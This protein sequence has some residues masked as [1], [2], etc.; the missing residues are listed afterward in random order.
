MMGKHANEILVMR[1]FFKIT[2]A[3]GSTSR[4]L[5]PK[6]ALCAFALHSLAIALLTMVF[7]GPASAT[8]IINAPM[9]DTNSTGWTLGGTPS[10]A[11]LTGN[12]AIDP[13]GNGWLRL[14]NATGNQTGFAY[15]NTAFDLSAGLLIEFDYATWGGTGA[16][17]YSVYL[18]DAGVSPFNIGAF[19]GSLGYAQKG[20]SAS[21]GACTS[22][23]NVPGISGGYVGIGVDEFGNFADCGEGRYLSLNNNSN[24]VPNTISIRGPV[25]GFGGGAVGSTQSTLSYP[26][27][28]TS[29]T[30]PSSL[31]YNG[32][33]RPAQTSVNYRHVRIQISPAPNPVANV[34]V[35]FGYS[36]PLVF[37]QMISNATLPT[38]STSQ[39]LMIGYAASTGGSTNYHEIRNLL[40]SNQ[41]TTS[42]IDLAITKTFT[43]V[44]TGST[45]TAS[46]G[47]QVRY[48]V[49]A[50]NTGPNNVT[51]T[52]VG[53]VDTVPAAITGVNW[54]CAGSGGAT[55]GAAS[56][57]G[58]NINTTANLPLYGYVTYTITGTLGTGA[59]SLLTN[60]AS[61][62][63]P[64]SV[65]DYN[66]TDDSATVSI[67]VTSVVTA[68]KSVVD[69]NNT[70][71]NATIG[72]VLQ[73]TITLTET[74][75]VPA[76]VSVTDDMPLNVTNFNVVSAPTGSDTSTPTGGANN[77]GYLNI[78][79]INIP[80][81]GTVSIV[82]A[83]SIAGSAV[84]GTVIGNTATVTN[85]GGSGATPSAP[86][87]IVVAGSGKKQLYLAGANQLSRTPT[88]SNPAAVSVNA[89]SSASWT[90]TPSLAGN[91]TLNPSIA[92]NVTGTLYMRGNS[93]T[94]RTI[95]VQLTCPTN[96]VA[97]PATPWAS[98]NFTLSTTT[99]TA[100]V[101]SLS[102]GGVSKTCP[103]GGQWILTVV[104]TSGGGR[105]ISIYPQSVSP[106]PAGIS[107]ILL[108]S[109]N[110]INVDSV[111]AYDGAYPAGA[112]LSSFTTGTIYVR[113][114]VSD[115][116]GYYDI[117][118]NNNATTQPTI[119][120]KDPSGNLVK[121]TAMPRAAA[122][123]NNP[124]SATRTFEYQFLPSPVQ[125]GNWTA[126]VTAPEGT[127]GTVSDTRIGTFLVVLPPPT[128]AKSFTPQSV[129]TNDASVLK[130]TLTNPNGAAITG[131]A[132]TDTYPSGL[133]STATPSTA[134]TCG[135]TVTGAANGNSL[136]LSNGTIPANGSCTV[137]I[138]AT[139]ATAGIYSN[140]TGTITSTNAVSAAPTSATLTV[141]NHPTV[142][143][144]FTP[145][146][147]VTNGTSTLT[148]NVTNSNSAI[149][150]GATFTDTYPANLKN[151]ASASA[152]TT[153][154]GCT[155]TL[156]GANNGTSLTLT[157]ANIP[158]N[159]T[160][161]FTVNVTS[162]TTGTYTNS[163]GTI[164]TT[165]AGSGT[166]ASASL[167]VYDPA[168]LTVLKS[169]NVA[170]ANPGQVITYTIQTANTGA[171]AGT[172]VVLKN[173]LSPYTAFGLN[174]YGANLPFSFTD[175]SPAS[176]LSLGTPVYSNDNGS[177]WTYTPVSGG[178][179][180]PAGYD[181]NITNWKI[182]MTGTI[183]AGGSFVLNYKTIVK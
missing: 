36:S 2:K 144:S 103:S 169:A 35:S 165:N 16:D 30:A 179:G 121:N 21:G 177:T 171:G 111:T 105:T 4:S 149:I 115:P 114:V 18:F 97:I 140:S 104:N 141:L 130:I 132:F 28:A 81:N 75:G 64:G 19:G 25:V 43:D 52:G 77:A 11:I 6:A 183:R 142:A 10:S 83:V 15:N 117:D 122:D 127:E 12:G 168:L 94:T 9:T 45:T 14:T 73:Y 124:T 67:P 70:L 69:L 128:V 24:V 134:T 98:G 158:A 13:V 180:A 50:S 34:W 79:N 60:T 41:N 133:V 176:G 92:T 129:G 59:P 22:T 23:A 123:P 84:N 135:G 106:S 102:L 100:V 109:A 26:W 51:A 150:T 116:F 93:T 86:N 8:I 139:S 31:W 170:N 152:T 164:T 65:T 53:I 131:A 88:S 74:A 162:A 39:Q 138:N 49:V 172:N 3:Y 119:V 90:L 113:A 89:G 161:T 163:T 101:F 7:A 87:V 27:V 175:S 37:T 5:H 44:T 72:D 91:D 143:T 181:G 62:V 61:L 154:T 166:A 159:A 147:V 40:V 82:F 96:G 54:T 156:T 71:A 99:N 20:T 126:T 167:S 155:G 68:T 78:T 63:I 148:I 1:Y 120:I 125:A 112:A 160:C 57:S 173:D 76:T 151:T 47:D 42:A 137:T 55:C 85:P 108:P 182:P 107:Q 29:A 33:P 58:N 95:T 145:S 174:S 38:I 110:V 17:G 46:V 146:T 56:G 118:A 66:S 136:T 80:A 32:S 157:G 48:T 178:G 153:G